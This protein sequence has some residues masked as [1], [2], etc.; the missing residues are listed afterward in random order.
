MKTEFELVNCQDVGTRNFV[1]IIGKVPN[2]APYLMIE[3]EQ[4]DDPT[5]CLYVTEKDLERLAVNI[6]KALKSKKLKS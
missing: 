3:T 5:N 6:L 2:D 1:R 4:N